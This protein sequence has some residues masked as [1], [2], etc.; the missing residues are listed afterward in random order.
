MFDR[1]QKGWELSKLSLKTIYEN[2]SLMIFPIISTLSLLAVLASFVFGIFVVG[3][4]DAK[5]YLMVAV[6][7][8]Y[9]VCYFLIIFFNSALIHCA[10]KIFKGEGATLNDGMSF[11]SSRIAKIFSW[12]FVSA[13]VGTLLNMLQNSNKA[14]EIIASI[15]G[16]VWSVMTFFVVPILIYEDKGV[17]E[18][19]KGSI[20]MMKEKWGESL[21]ANFSF[22][23]FQFIGI[24]IGVALG[25]L[26]G[27]IHPILGI[28]VG[29]IIV[30]LVSIATSAATTVFIAA[31]YSNTKGLPTGPFHADILDSAFS[32]K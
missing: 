20:K 4:D 10:M 12:A 15:I 31:V 32:Q 2:K 23:I 18:S 16:I 5:S 6:F 9:L 25:F 22:G 28:L 29:G 27:A 1:F 17:M 3:M 19:I 14:G 11:A 30:A 13:I 7:P 8:F 26:F 24:L 21:A